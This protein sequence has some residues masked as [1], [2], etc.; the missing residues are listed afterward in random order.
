VWLNGTIWVSKAWIKQAS[1]GYQSQRLDSLLGGEDHCYNV[2]HEPTGVVLM[3]K[4]PPGED[5]VYRGQLA[6]GPN[7]EKYYTDSRISKLAPFVAELIESRRNYM[8]PK[9]KRRKTK[10]VS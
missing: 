2:W 1:V 6:V 3:Y 7:F 5:L 8:K 9:K 10:N 4:K